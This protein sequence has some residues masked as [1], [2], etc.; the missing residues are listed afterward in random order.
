MGVFLQ[1]MHL[2]VKMIDNIFKIP[3]K[4]MRLSLHCTFFLM[5]LTPR[6]VSSI[7][8]RRNHSGH[9]ARAALGSYAGKM[10]SYR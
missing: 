9:S 6:D 1:S 8:Q 2:W 10:D 3:G 7:G 5:A 4:N